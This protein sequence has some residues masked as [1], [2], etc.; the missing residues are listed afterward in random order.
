MKDRA[1]RIWLVGMMGSGK[2]T[3]GAALAR[4]LGWQAIDTDSLIEREVGERIADLWGREG[5]AAFRAKESE[6]I[7][8]VA[9]GD[10]HRV[11][12]VGGGAVLDPGNR[13]QLSASGLVVWLRADA[14]TLLARVGAG[15]ERPALGGD[16]RATLARIDAD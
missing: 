11:V 6:V 4:R 8:R 5:E 15:V 12:S 3:V 13:E 16:P 10:D 2:S 14:A 9:A 1:A 7:T